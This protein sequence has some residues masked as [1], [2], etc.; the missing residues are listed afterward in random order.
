MLPYTA[1]FYANGTIFDSVGESNAHYTS[2]Y[3]DGDVVYYQQANSSEVQSYNINNEQI[4]NLIA[5][6]KSDAIP[7]KSIVAKQGV[8]YGFQ[9]YTAKPFDD[10]SVL[11]I[12]DNNT[13]VRE[14]YDFTSTSILL[15]SQT[16]IRDFFVDEQS[17]Y[18]VI[19]NRQTLTKFTKERNMVYSIKSLAS[20]SAFANVV[21]L[22]ANPE[23]IAVDKV[24][25]HSNVGLREYPVVL[26][27]I[28]TGQMFLAKINDTTGAFSNVTLLPISGEFYPHS[29]QRHVNYNLTNYSWLNRKHGNSK[30]QL[31]FKLTLK[32]IYNNRDVISLDMPVDVSKYT[33]GYHH[34]VFRLDTI[35]GKVSLFVDGREHTTKN[36]PPTNYTFQDVTQDSMCVGTTYF[37]NNIP[38]FAKLKQPN[39]YTTDNCR[40][41]QFRVYD[42]AITN[43]EI[44]LLT[45]NNTKL[46]DLVL[47]LPCGQRN[48]LD[49]IERI[50]SF[51]VPG[52]RSN[53]I[54]VIVKNSNINNAQLQDKVREVMTE[55]LKKVLPVATKINSITFRDTRQTF[56]QR[57]SA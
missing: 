23:L 12:T 31:T 10:N 19:H 57:L 56:N 43:D 25:E 24:R 50:F 49:Q 32:N 21:D 34:F 36:I 28:N 22:S 30:Q 14:R 7:T 44:R 5:V 45:Y 46:N 18:Y 53:Y 17:N 6:V 20:N 11:Y 13:L 41:K 33:S 54:N 16:Y 8:V 42:K 29:D 55:R 39:F 4:E 9:G 2:V 51:N 52:N 37:Y 38:L 1:K 48:E 47:S 35:R 3:R 26:G 27:K 40:I 15:S